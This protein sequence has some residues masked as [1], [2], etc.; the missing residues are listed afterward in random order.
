MIV[1]MK[2]EFVWSCWCGKPHSGTRSVARCCHR[3]LGVRMTA[4]IC[5]QAL[6]QNLGCVYDCGKFE[7]LGFLEKAGVLLHV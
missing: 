6:S 4:E 7:V 1:S 5:R 2:Y 3:T